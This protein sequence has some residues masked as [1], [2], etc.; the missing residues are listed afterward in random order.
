MS[1]G[2]AR[3]LE[4]GNFSPERVSV[5]CRSYRLKEDAAEQGL[6]QNGSDPRRIGMIHEALGALIHH[7]HSRQAKTRQ[8]ASPSPQSGEHLLVEQKAS[9]ERAV[10]R[11]IEGPFAELRLVALKLQGK[12]Q[13]VGQDR[14]PDSNKDGAR[15]CQYRCPRS[16]AAPN[17]M[18]AAATET[19]VCNRGA[20]GFELCQTGFSGKGLELLRAGQSTVRA[21]RVMRMSSDRL[22]ACIFVIRLARY[23]STVRGLMPR[24]CAMVLF[25]LPATSPSSTWRSR[26]ESEAR[27]AATKV[28]SSDLR[29]SFLPRSSAARTA[30]R[31]AS[32][33]N[34][35]SMKSR[36]PDFI[37]STASGM[38]PCPVITMTGSLM[39]LARNRCRSSMP[40]M[41]GM[42]TSVIRQPA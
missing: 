18:N 38:S 26:S 7:E 1:R 8:D 19:R 36:A 14:I 30:R 33:A 29:P 10:S 11:R 23:T 24:A 3:S 28:S 40:V 22:F 34:G 4:G 13:G 32:S 16:R 41:S 12:A 35:F 25:A 2:R 42:R 20:A 6:F 27:R 21:A 5:Q 9:S 17:P 39:F 15:L 37:A 31:I